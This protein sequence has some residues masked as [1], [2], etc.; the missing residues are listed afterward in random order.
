[1][2]KKPADI[3]KYLKSTLEN[4]MELMEV[5]YLAQRDLIGVMI[6]RINTVLKEEEE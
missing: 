3:L 5:Q 4:N 1:M 6:D 2:S